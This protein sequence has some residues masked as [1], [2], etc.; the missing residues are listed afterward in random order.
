MSKKVVFKSVLAVAMLGFVLVFSS[1]QKEEKKIIG[2]WKYKNV[3]IRE[4]S[5]T[6]P[7]LDAGMRIGLSTM[8]PMYVG[9]MFEGT[10]EFTK[11]GKVI[12]QNWGVATTYKITDGKLVITFDDG[13]VWNLNYSISDKGKMY[14]DAN[15]LE[16]FEGGILEITTDTEEIGIAKLVVRI[17]FDKQ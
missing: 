9:N 7:L 17:T 2:T 5:S 10:I 12:N 4:F 6:N 16:I 15:L 8:A 1:C 11:K 3:E 13:K 14:W